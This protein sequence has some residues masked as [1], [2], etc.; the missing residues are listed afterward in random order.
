MDQTDLLYRI[1]AI[2]FPVFSIVAI[3]YLYARYRQETDMASGNR[4]N[5]DIFT[6]A[7]IFDYMSASEVIRDALRLKMQAEEAYQ[8]KLERLRG[9]IKAGWD[10]LD[11]GETV[12]FDV[13]TFLATRNNA[14]RRD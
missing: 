10:Q 3:G 12:E 13:E 4:I 7:L 11:R 1:V 5:M 9:D 8:T 14:D 6:P 2:I